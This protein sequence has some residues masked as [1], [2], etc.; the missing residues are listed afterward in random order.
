MFWTLGKVLG[1]AYSAE[2]HESWVRLFSS[3]IRVIIPIAVHH[4]LQDNTAQ[5]NRFEK[6]FDRDYGMCYTASRETKEMM[7]TYGHGSTR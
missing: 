5:K 6:Q 7:A 3:M 1:Q 4:E 2:A